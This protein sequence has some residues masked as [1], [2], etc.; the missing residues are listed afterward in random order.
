M[1]HESDPPAKGSEATSPAERSRE[2]V[3]DSGGTDTT[4]AT[5]VLVSAYLAMWA[6]L[7]VFVWLAWRRQERLSL[8]LA[9]LERA[10]QT[11][12]AKTP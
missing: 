9:E 6:L 10:L 12:A 1:K 4:S 2:F 7:F 3:A 8:R 11:R 5:A